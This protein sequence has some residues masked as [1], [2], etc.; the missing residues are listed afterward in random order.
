MNHRDTKT[1]RRLC[2][3][4]CLCVFVVFPGSLPLFCARA[5][6]P[7][8]FAVLKQPGRFAQHVAHFNE[9]EDEP[10]ANFIPN[11][12]AWAWMEER[13]PRFECSDAEVEEMYWFRWWALRKQLRR[14]ETSGRFV[15]TEFITKPKPVSSA[16]GHH[17]MEGRWLRDQTYH[18]DYVLYWLRDNDGNPQQHLHKYSSWLEIG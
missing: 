6:E 11:A 14:D 12:E 3:P 8:P 13:V 7:S 2:I 4:L 15:F 18:E 10:V 5:A 9:M 16:L 1:Q 17:L